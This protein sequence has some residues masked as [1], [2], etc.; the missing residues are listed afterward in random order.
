MVYEYN[1]FDC[2]VTTH[3]SFSL[4]STDAELTGGG[5]G[6]E[7]RS[8]FKCITLFVLGTRSHTSNTHLHS[9]ASIIRSHSHQHESKHCTFW[10]V[11]RVFT[12]HLHV[13]SNGAPLGSTA[14]TC[15]A[16]RACGGALFDVNQQFTCARMGLRSA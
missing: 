8:Y 3:R 1:S 16:Y 7:P 15:N 11:H 12:V 6:V 13:S 4:V 14:S 2:D 5:R 9:T 10:D